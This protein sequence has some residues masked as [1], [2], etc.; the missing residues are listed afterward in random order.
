MRLTVELPQYFLSCFNTV[1]LGF[2][3]NGNAAKVGVGEEDSAIEARQAAPFFGENRADGGADHGVAHAHDVDAGDALA[4]VGVDAL[5]VVENGFFP[6]GPISFEKNLA[7]LRRRAFGESP[8]E[9]PDGAVHV[10]AQALMHGVDVAER[11]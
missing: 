5:E 2:L 4:N 6:V 1:V 10:R 8:I 11:R 3:E 9:S 7:V